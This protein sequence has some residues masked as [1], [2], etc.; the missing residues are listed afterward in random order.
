MNWSAQVVNHQKYEIATQNVLHT[1]HCTLVEKVT[2][3]NYRDTEEDFDD[4][5]VEHRHRVAHLVWLGAEGQPQVEA[6]VGRRH[7]LLERQTASE[8]ASK[9]A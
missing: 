9:T 5:E 7:Q 3:R 1:R 4:V 8:A 6:R 2:R